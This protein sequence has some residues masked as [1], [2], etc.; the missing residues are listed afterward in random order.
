M[1]DWSIGNGCASKRYIGQ[2]LA[3]S[4]YFEAMQP[5]VA[6]IIATE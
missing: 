5:H 4:T 1:G 3:F 6:A 2:I